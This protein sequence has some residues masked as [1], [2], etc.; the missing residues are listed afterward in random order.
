MDLTPPLLV[1]T[2]VRLEPL[3]MVHADDLLVSAGYDEIWT[4]LDEPTPRRFEDIAR[5]LSDALAESSDGNRMPFAIVD[6]ATGQAIGSVSLIDIRPHDRAVEIGWAWLTPPR[7][8][9]GAYREAIY[10]LARHAFETM[11]AIRVVYK[12]DSRNIRSQRSIEALGGTREGVFRNHR[13]LSDGYI[14][15]SIYYSIIPAEWLA[16]R[17]RYRVSGLTTSVTDRYRDAGDTSG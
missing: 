10:L 4:Y 2:M 14:R 1:G 3:G 9:T 17:D 13:I 8:G 15:D 6:A 7:W 5:L 11:N 16:I 12:T